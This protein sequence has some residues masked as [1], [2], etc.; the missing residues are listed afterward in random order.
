[1]CIG[2]VIT[3]SIIIAIIIIIADGDAPRFRLHVR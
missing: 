2:I 1:M 3:E